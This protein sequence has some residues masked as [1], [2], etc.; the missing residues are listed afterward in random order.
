MRPVLLLCLIAAPALAQT[1]AMV[2]ETRDVKRVAGTVTYTVTAPNLKAA[3]WVVFAASAPEL[4]GQTRVKSTLGPMGASAKELSPLARPV[5]VGRV[6]GAGG[7][8]TEVKIEVAYEATLRSRR[9]RPLAEG[10]KA[11]AVTAL[12]AAARAAALGSL[13]ELDHADEGFR[14]W[15]KDKGFL[16]KKGEGDLDL[17]RRVFL[18]L[19]SGSS[20][21]YKAGMDRKASAV[22]KTLKSDCG[23]LAA[24]FVAA[25]RANKVPARSLYGRWAMSAKPEEKIGGVAYFQWH[26][27]AEFFAEKVGWVPV[28]VSSGVLHDKTPAGLRYFGNDDGDFITFHVDPDLKV[29]TFHF[30]AQAV[31]NLQTPAYWV[32]GGGTLKGMTTKEGWVVRPVK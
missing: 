15:L 23:G 25:M 19:R 2:L 3:E 12:T 16:R 5:L 14:K 26:V 22:C 4:P 9:L 13:G 6:P 32:S 11:P 18:A 31:G 8:Q 29:N 17:G 30:G 28:D 24:V 7:R 1:R 27:K 20:Y 10:E 21:E